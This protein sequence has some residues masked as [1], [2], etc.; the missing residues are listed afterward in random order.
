MFDRYQPV[1]LPTRDDPD[2]VRS[3]GKPDPRLKADEVVLG[4]WTGK[5]ARAYPLSVLERQ[6]IL[7]EQQGEPVVV[8]WEPRTR[9]ATAYRPIASQPRTFKGPRPDA[10]GVSPPDEGVPVP[11]DAPIV[12]PRKLSLDL[13]TKPGAGRF[14]DMETGSVW[15]IAGRCVE[16]KLKGWTLEWADSVQVKWFA[17]AA[18]YPQTT[19][20][21][22]EKSD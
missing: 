20:F 15:D 17:W 22:A 9:T 16:G 13:A 6:G 10:T 7:K 18:E 14:V 19:V 1:E 21:P 12:P 4:V 3:R 8:L 5:T 2:S 11:P